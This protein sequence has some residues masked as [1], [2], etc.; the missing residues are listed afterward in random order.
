MASKKYSC[1]VINGRFL[2]QKITGVQRFA[3]E[4]TKALDEFAAGASGTGASS[5]NPLEYILAISPAVAD[6]VI[7]PLKNIRIERVGSR[8][9]ILWEQTQL[10]SYL[11]KKK[12]LVLNLCNVTTLFYHKAIVCIHDICYSLHPEFVSSKNRLV[13]AWHVL[14][15]RTSAKKSL[16]VLTVSNFCKQEIINYYSLA[17][18]KLVVVYNGWQ[19]FN[20]EIEKDDFDQRFSFL[21]DG[22]YYYTMS[23]LKRNKNFK[24]IVENAKN[25]PDKVY[26]VAG[27]IDVKKFG[28][29]AEEYKAPNIHYL[30]YVSDEEAKILMKHAKAFLFPS[31]YEGFGIPPLEALAMGTPVISSN[32]TC[33]PEIFGDSVHY[34]DPLNAQVD[35]ES[36]LAQPAGDAE[37]VLSKYS[38]RNSAK[39]VSETVVNCVRQAF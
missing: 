15:D 6:E 32:A 30:G 1:V 34:I 27:K 16:K 3:L 22:Q 29:S 2:E 13:R 8:S 9:G 18:E 25:N 31:L 4:V 20:P 36:I 39:I 26:A 35:L 5:G 24:W 28:T 10:V 14:Q 38:W 37:K 21:K 11:R 7:P 23:T 17:P 19:H 33:L 12:A